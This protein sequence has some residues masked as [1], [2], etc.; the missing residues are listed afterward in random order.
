MKTPHI[1]TT[2]TG[3]NLF[4]TLGDA[5]RLLNEAGRP[6]LIEQM[7]DQ[8]KTS[9]SYHAALSAILRTLA[10]AGIEVIGA[11]DPDTSA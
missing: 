2:L 8:V 5:R 3:G 11:D 6:D 9:Q 1:T 4:G 7:F 10:A